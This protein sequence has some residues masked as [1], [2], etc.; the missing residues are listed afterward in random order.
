VPLVVGARKG[1]PNFNEF[2]META[3]NVTRKMQILAQIGK[4]ANQLRAT[5]TNQMY[6]V[7]ISNVFG[8]EAWNS[9]S[10][11]YPRDLQMYVVTDMHA[12]VT[13]ELGR[14]INNP[15]FGASI[16]FSTNRLIKANDWKGFRDTHNAT[17][18]FLM[19]LAPPGSPVNHF[20]SLAPST[21]SLKDGI[22]EAPPALHFEQDQN[23]PFALPHW[24]LRLTTRLRFVLVDVVVNRIV[25]YVNLSTTDDPLDITYELMRDA[26][27]ST[28]N[29]STTHIN[30]LLWCTNRSSPLGPTFGSRLQLELSLGLVE[31]D[32][33]QY[34]ASQEQFRQ[35]VDFFRSNFFGWPPK[36]SYGYP[37]PQT[38]NFAA[39]PV[40]RTLYITTSWQAN[41]PLVHYTIG[42]LL[43]P[44]TTN[45]VQPNNVLSQYKISNIGRINNRYEPWGGNPTGPTHS[46]TTFEVGVKDPLVRRSD[47]WDF[48][49]E[50]RLDIA[51]L[52]KIHR[53]TPWQTIYLKSLVVSPTNWA[54]WLGLRDPKVALQTHPT[55]D[56]RMVSSLI[57]LLAK[58]HP[59]RLVSVNQATPSDWQTVL[60]GIQVLTNTLSSNPSPF[61]V[62][63]FDSSVM[64]PWSPQIETIVADINATRA[65]QPSQTWAERGD[66]LA[67]PA[68]SV[69]SPWLNTSSLEQVRWGITDEAYEMIPSQI[70][71]R[72]RS[73]SIGCV[74]RLNT[75]ANV[76]F[77]GMPGCT[78]I[79]EVSSDL[80]HWQP[81]STNCCR[82]GLITLPDDSPRAGLKRFY[83]TVLR[84]PTGSESGPGNAE[85]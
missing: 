9:Y 55:N 32:W 33:R 50:E 25:D 11:A 54:T 73:D 79:V 31:T 83:R 40:S 10:N 3:V 41:D 4:P 44:L 14:V 30:G 63:E 80:I 60:N 28:Y 56:W 57:P 37:V 85:P 47:D 69:N 1:L 27:C 13:N 49:S 6:V 66:I 62:P 70:L 61:T 8:V 7:T 34:A 58:E 16:Q 64:R 53:G 36:Y 78:Y 76:R 59:H 39:L 77:T 19:P 22:F 67:T 84:P 24:W 71:Q 74:N 65:L 2:S 81:V 43:D 21:Y 82:N 15:P 48:P 18:S 23:P 75:E 42:D 29:P 45:H 26:D 17:I 38:N 5:A 72:L 12:V 68:L 51:S 35:Y 52:G 46:R 20:L